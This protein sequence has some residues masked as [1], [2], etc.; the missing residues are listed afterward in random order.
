M[1]ENF[2]D[3]KEDVLKFSEKYRSENGIK[4]KE[5]TE[6]LNRNAKD[7]GIPIRVYAGA[8]LEMNWDILSL[9]KTGQEEKWT[10]WW[11]LRPAIPEPG[12]RWAW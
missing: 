11:T 12:K 4:I 5:K 3:L 2:L 7:A 10:P 1:E 6:D 9:L 8:E